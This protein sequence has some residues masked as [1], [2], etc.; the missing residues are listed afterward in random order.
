MVDTPTPNKHAQVDEEVT[1]YNN[2]LAKFLTAEEADWEA[3]VA[4][5]R[6]DLQRPFFEHMQCLIAAA[7]DEEGEWW[8][9]V[10][11]WRGAALL[12]GGLL[13]LEWDAVLVAVF[14]SVTST[15]PT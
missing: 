3:V 13:G 14:D 15:T 6:G 9:S 4:T 1:R 7:K 10:G 8:S 11:L 12:G 2:V 5:Y